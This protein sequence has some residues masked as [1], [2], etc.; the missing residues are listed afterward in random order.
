MKSKEKLLLLI[1][2]IDSQLNN[3]IEIYNEI[4]IQNTKDKKDIVY[5]GYLIHNYYCSVEDIF[6]EIAR[7]F[8]NKIDDVSKYHRELLKRMTI[9]IPG[10]RPKLLSNKNFNFFDEL[11]GFRHIFRHAYG[12]TIDSD[13]IDLLKKKMV[14]HHE[15]FLEDLKKFKSFLEENLS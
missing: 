6:I 11:R 13:K 1:G 12:Y 2:Y 9:D 15:F 14:E 3:I 8:E 5:V 7:T 10:I 4:K